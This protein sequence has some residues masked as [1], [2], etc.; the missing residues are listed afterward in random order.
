MVGVI[1]PDL[2]GTPNHRLSCTP[3]HSIYLFAL[4]LSD[5]FA[6]TKPKDVELKETRKRDR[7]KFSKDLEAMNQFVLK[8]QLRFDRD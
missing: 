5:K 1:Q 6:Q 8:N 2:R 3:K 7:K 4:F